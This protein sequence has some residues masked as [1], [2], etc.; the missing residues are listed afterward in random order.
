MHQSISEMYNLSNFHS[1]Y[2]YRR[3][4]PD[5][6]TV[7]IIAQLTQSFKRCIRSTC[8][9]YY[10]SFSYTKGGEFIGYIGHKKSKFCSFN[11]H[12]RH[13]MGATIFARNAGSL[14]FIALAATR[15][16]KTRS[17]AAA[18]PKY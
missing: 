17:M 5:E 16:L 11:G 1:K 7:C 12:S 8:P 13:F 14:F 6:A 4:A 10:T 18:E 15:L 9:R 2:M 3:N